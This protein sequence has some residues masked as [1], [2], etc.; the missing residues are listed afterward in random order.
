MGVCLLSSVSLYSQIVISEHKT[1]S[2]SFP[3]YTSQKKTAVWVDSSDYE[4]VRKCANLFAEDIGRVTGVEGLVSSTYNGVQNR[5]WV[6]IGTIGKSRY[7]DSLIKEGKLDVSSINGK[8]ESFVV[9]VVENPMKGLD[10]ALVIAGS[11]RRGTSYGAFAVSE[12]MGVS[13]LYWWADVPV[14]K[15]KSVYQIGRA[16]V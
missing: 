6:L 1:Q 9:K 16:H 2:N 13:P 14:K 3:V 5:S 11:D 10:R 4:S 15:K 12:A 7:I 8:W